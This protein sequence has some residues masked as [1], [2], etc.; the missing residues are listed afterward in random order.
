MNDLPCAIKDKTPWKGP[1][2]PDCYDLS[3]IQFV[4]KQPQIVAVFGMLVKDRSIV[5][6]AL[7]AQK[8]LDTSHR[9][10]VK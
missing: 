4:C 5:Y 9:Y 3:F 6:I 10:G 7:T 8:I 1:R 2:S